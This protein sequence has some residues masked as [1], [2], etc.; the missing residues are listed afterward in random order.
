[1]REH[2]RTINGYK[3]LI[4]ISYMQNYYIKTMYYIFKIHHVK[5][6]GKLWP[7]GQIWPASCICMAHKLRMD[8]T[9]LN[10]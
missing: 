9:S 3:L 8:A 7:A 2:I 5:L 1:M 10:R 4:M 6:V